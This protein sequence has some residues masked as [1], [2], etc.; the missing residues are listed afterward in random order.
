MSLNRVTIIGNLGA[1]PQIKSTVSNTICSFSVATNE[2][3]RTGE[4]GKQHTEWHQIVVFGKLA[5][6]CLLY[7]KKG[8][9]VFLEGRLR[10]NTYQDKEGKQQWRTR[11]YS[12]SVKFLDSAKASD[13]THPL[14]VESEDELLTVTES[15]YLE[16]A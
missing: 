11:I 9:R 3:Y 16:L 2:F 8:N 15:T 12:S 1:D 7:L 14:S 5:Q 6:T 4:E 10:T 13:S